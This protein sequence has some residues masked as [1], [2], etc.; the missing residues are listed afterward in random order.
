MNHSRGVLKRMGAALSAESVPGGGVTDPMRPAILW[1]PE[2]P[3]II[4]HSSAAAVASAA[5]L[6]L[7]SPGCLHCSCDPPALFSEAPDSTGAPHRRGPTVRAD[8]AEAVCGRQ[9]WASSSGGWSRCRAPRR[10]GGTVRGSTIVAESAWRSTSMPCVR[11]GCQ[12]LPCCELRRGRTL[13]G[14]GKRRNTVHDRR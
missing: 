1:Y 6:A 13:A 2:L 14:E 11:V 12:Q 7:V 9:R 3:P 8:E 5:A 10:R 4:G